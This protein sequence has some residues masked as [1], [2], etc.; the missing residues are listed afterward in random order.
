MYINLFLIPFIILL[1]LLLSSRDNKRTRG[2]F[3][4]ICSIV[5]LFFAVLRSPEWMTSQ[6]GIDT[7]NYK[8]A[9]LSSFD[10]DWDV[11]LNLFN[12]R[13]F[14]G[15][16]E[17]DI[18]YVGLMFVIGKLTHDFFVFSFLADL[19]FFIPF[20]IILYRFSTNIAQLVFAFV[21][22]V[23]LLQ[24]SFLAGGRQ[25]F[26]IGVDMMAL[27]AMFDGRKWRSLLFWLLGITIHFSSLIF[28][29]PLLLI[30]FNVR[31][32][33]LKWAHGLCMLLIP[34]TIL[35]P[36][37]IVL[38]M[39]NLSGMEK[40]AQ[41]GLGSIHGGA[42][43]FISLIE[44]LSLFCLIAIKKTD[45]QLNQTYRNFYVMV[46]LFTFFAPLIISNGSMIRISLYF[47]IY[48]VLL[49]P[50]AIECMFKG[51]NKRTIYF[52]TIGLLSFLA[53]Q[54]G[55]IEYYFFWQK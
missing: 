51:G 46:P 27:L 12:Q 49:V 7:L 15:G 35:F 52:V 33:A 37:Q 4:I 14:G 41:Y 40:Y 32:I 17:D 21:F 16:S 54:G 9:F 31:P 48:L 34:I 44:V 36:N 18:G 30:M 38:F 20:G 3:I 45:M 24:I 13:Y 43:T 55:G 10:I 25:S 11:F 2:Q 23:A 19:V 47:H 28:L 42:L 22:Y 53:L 5:L 8:E 1:G 29:A 50:F 26:A 6:Y 39:G